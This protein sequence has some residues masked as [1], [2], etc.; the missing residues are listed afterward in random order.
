[1]AWGKPKTVRVQNSL[2]Q[3]NR[4]QVRDLAMIMTELFTRYSASPINGNLLGQCA[5]QAKMIYEKAQEI[6]DHL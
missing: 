6:S 4:E 1:M 3:D 2:V 5:L